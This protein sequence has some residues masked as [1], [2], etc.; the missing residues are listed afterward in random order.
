M[1]QADRW[2]EV[3]ALFVAALDRAPEARSDFLAAACGDD[4][5]LRHDVETLLAADMQAGSFIETPVASIPIAGVSEAESSAP[6]LGRGDRLGPYEIVELIGAGGMGEVYK[7]RDSRLGRHVAMKLLVDDCEARSASALNHP[8]IV[9]IYDVGH[10][11]VGPRS[12]AYLAM[13]LVDGETLRSLL[14]NGALATRQLL[15]LAAQIADGL[16]AAH[17]LGIVHRDLKPE[18]IMI[19]AEGRAKILDF[20]L[21]SVGAVE[22]AGVARLVGTAAYMSPQQACGHAVDFRS[23]QFSFGAIL[24]EMA[25]G[26]HPF[27]RDTLDATLTAIASVEAEPLGHLVSDLS[28]PFQWIVTR[29]LAKDP[30]D[31]YASTDMLAR[32]IAIVREHVERGEPFVTPCTLPSPRTPLIGRDQPLAAA[33]DLLMSSDVRL[34]TL[35]GP[36]GCGKTRLAIQIAV[37]LIDRFSGGVHFIGLA[38]A[39]D[40]ATVASAVRQGGVNRAGRRPTLLVLDN[41]EQALSAAPVTSELL[42]ASPSLKILVTSRAPLVVHGEREFRVPPLAQHDAVALFVQRARAAGADFTSTEDVMR[43]IAEIC[44]RLDGLPLAIELAAART[45]LFSPIAMLPRLYRRLPLLTGG[46]RDAPERHRTLRQTIDWSHE[47]LTP[48]EQK[49]F[50]RL[51]VFVGGCSV[52]AA[53]AVCDVKA[54]LGVDLLEGL[55][56]LIDHSLI[57]RSDRPDGEPRFQML[58][59]VREYGLERLTASGDEGSVRRAHAAYWLIVAEEAEIAL[60]SSDATTNW[61]EQLSA[62]RDNL[63]AALDWLAQTGHA[64]WGLRLCNALFL[65]W[66]SR[67]PAEGCERL[68][69]F[70]KQ[71]A[72]AAVPKLVA[73]ALSTAGGLALD[74]ADFEAARD[75]N[76]RA[77]VMHREVGNPGGVLVC[78]NNLGVL[79]REQGDYAEAESVFVQIVQ[80][81]RKTGDLA[82]VAHAMSNLADVARAQGDW[83]RARAIHAECLEIVRSVGDAAAMAWSLNHQADVAREQGDVAAA[84]TLY[85]QALDMFRDQNHLAAAHSLVD[86]AGLARDEGDWRTAQSLYGD[87]LSIFRARGETVEVAATLEQLMSCAVHE[88]QWDRA[89]RLAAAASALRA[90]LGSK[91]PPSRAAKL[92]R[93]LSEARDHLPP[94]DAAL[95]WMEGSA[96]SLAEIVALAVQ[97]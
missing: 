70:A 79:H 22:T 76:E 77:L 86:L 84:R 71:P 47:L 45:K 42:D 38:S 7:A 60:A 85:Q 58:E 8:N 24:Y 69:A 83:P 4:A 52:E 89:V 50:R 46:P 51:S 80:L 74:Q 2:S 10:A 64:E 30:A 34:L 75:L 19:S 95:A 33:R 27:S 88:A 48:A 36:G 29:C 82:S 59:T 23:D 78:L 18:N 12:V 6:L 44:A 94:T 26:Q 56:S 37:D 1:T 13:E 97:V 90:K 11:V 53:Q 28:A 62:E 87:A 63:R 66:K 81:L 57:S 35:V 41:F 67:A 5:A 31:R 25:T 21:A 17:K 16:A 93:H 55:T 73:K 54:D 91:R 65:Y 43:A 68:L 96:L 14:A 92:E 40:R 20:G 72:G 15:D 39:T 49:L 61:I 9:T 3:K 32:E